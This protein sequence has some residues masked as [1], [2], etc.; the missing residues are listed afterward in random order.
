MI[1]AKTLA[2]SPT[3]SPR[4]FFFPPLTAE[5]G[6]LKTLRANLQGKGG[7]A[8]SAVAVRTNSLTNCPKAPTTWTAWSDRSRRNSNLSCL[9]GL[10][11]CQLLLQLRAHVGRIMNAPLSNGHDCLHDPLETS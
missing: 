2:L 1:A 8:V 9:T 4:T 11:I 10:H 3:D 7:L 6:E 5:S